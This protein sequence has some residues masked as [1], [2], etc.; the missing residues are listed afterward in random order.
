MALD[1]INERRCIGCNEV[2]PLIRF[3]RN[4]HNKHG[5][6]YRCAICIN[7][8]AALRRHI[9]QQQRLAATDP[10]MK[11]C[12]NCATLKKLTDFYRNK[13]NANGHSTQCK[14]CFA[15]YWRKIKV[16]PEFQS[17]R[18]E[19]RKKYKATP[20]AKD[21][22]WASYLNSQHGISVEQYIEIFTTQGG[23][24]AICQQL[25]NNSR[26]VVD[27]DHHTGIIRGLLCRRH[28]AGMGFF[29]D[30]ADLM[31]DAA[32]YLRHASMDVNTPKSKSK[33]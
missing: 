13:A 21:S 3:H 2:K 19:R 31:E 11:K 29:N 8:A 26:L 32:R 12:R 1:S 24:C 15:N 7:N 25:P 4:S 33:R 9:Q 14:T 27:H 17:K 22:N 23:V 28:N 20:R 16:L 5:R 10:T 30:S 6:E 18:R